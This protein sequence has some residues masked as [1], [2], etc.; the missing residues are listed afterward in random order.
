MWLSI[1]SFHIKASFWAGAFAQVVEPLP[2]K[3]EA[4]SSN[5][6]TYEKPKK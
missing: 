5:S 4:L 1:D 3:H 6:S 2:S